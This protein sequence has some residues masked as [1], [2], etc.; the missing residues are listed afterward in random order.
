M[1]NYIL[2]LIYNCFILLGCQILYHSP[3]LFENAWGVTVH[4]SFKMLHTESQVD[5]YKVHLWPWFSAAKRQLTFSLLRVTS[6]FLRSSFRSLQDLT[7]TYLSFSPSLLHQISTFSGQ[8]NLKPLA[9]ANAL[10]SL[11][12]KLMLKVLFLSCENTPN[13]LNLHISKSSSNVT[14]KII[15]KGTMSLSS[16]QTGIFMSVIS[17][18]LGGHYSLY[19]FLPRDMCSRKMCILCQDTKVSRTNCMRKS[20]CYPDLG[21][22]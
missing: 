16:E 1:F 19:L 4:S 3:F 12:I 13:L 20:I 7:L 8:I 9:L 6:E 5:L 18:L 2:V 10:W 22:L 21:I 14:S 15:L 11:A 17:L